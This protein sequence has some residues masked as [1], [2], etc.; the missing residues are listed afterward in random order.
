MKDAP[1]GLDVL[2]GIAQ[3][4]VVYAVLRH[5][6]LV[7]RESAGTCRTGAGTRSG[8]CSPPM[9]AMWN[10]SRVAPP[11]SIDVRFLG[12]CDNCPSS[13]LTFVAGVKQAIA[14]HCPEIKNIRHVKGDE[15]IGGHCFHQSVCRRK[16]SAHGFSWPISMRFRMAVWQRLQLQASAVLQPRARRVSGFHNLCP[17]FGLRSPGKGRERPDRLPAS[18]IHFRSDVRRMPDRAGRAS[19]SHACRLIGDRVEISL[20]RLVMRVSLRSAMRPDMMDGAVGLRACRCSILRG[21]SASWVR[22]SAVRISCSRSCLR[23]RRCSARVA[24]PWPLPTAPRSS[25][26]PAII[27]CWS[28]TSGRRDDHVAA[29]FCIGQSDFAHEGRNAKGPPNGAS[30]NVPTGVAATRDILAVADAWNH[31]VLIW[32]GLPER[33]RPADVVLGQVDFSATQANRGGEVTAD[34][35]ELVLWRRHH[36]HI[37]HRLRHRQSPCSRLARNPVAPRRASRSCSRSK[38]HGLPR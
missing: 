18:R 3:D 13:T 38:Q 2:H 16:T 1:G 33:S 32:H 21:L 15:H 25:P 11:E 14:D 10:W 6:G 34:K 27:A 7:A 24:R 22:G 19:A 9:A 20:R 17:H 4:P 26:I 30:F 28:G 8:R 31:R 36:R 12:N 23:L 5:H 35:L 29:D 37:A